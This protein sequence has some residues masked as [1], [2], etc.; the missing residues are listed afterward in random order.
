MLTS[1]YKHKERMADLTVQVDLVTSE[2]MIMNLWSQSD[3]A[4]GGVLRW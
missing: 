4:R 2:L 1:G 3:C